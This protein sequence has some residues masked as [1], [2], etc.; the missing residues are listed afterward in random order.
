M[1]HHDAGD[2]AGAANASTLAETAPNP[3]G[4]TILARR[5]NMLVLRPL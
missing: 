1:S 4:A 5:S 3:A 2:T